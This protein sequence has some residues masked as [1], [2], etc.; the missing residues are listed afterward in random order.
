M[1]RKKRRGYMSTSR[2]VMRY[3]HIMAWAC[4]CVVATDIAIVVSR[5]TKMCASVFREY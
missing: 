2:R 3:L 1:A 4:G 5:A